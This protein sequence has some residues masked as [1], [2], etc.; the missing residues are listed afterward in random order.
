MTD[1]LLW[2]AV[3][4]GCRQG[5]YMGCHLRCLQ[6]THL[7]PAVLP[8][9]PGMALGPT[10]T[11]NCS[12][13]GPCGVAPGGLKC[14][15]YGKYLAFSK[16]YGTCTTRCAQCEHMPSSPVEQYSAAVL[17]RMQES[18]PGHQAM[19]HSM[20]ECWCHSGSCLVCC[21]HRRWPCAEAEAQVSMAVVQYTHSI[22]F[23]V[24]SDRLTCR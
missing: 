14:T 1:L 6:S 3:F 4:H 15:S 24:A 2:L 21:R 10:T 17:T 23:G 18:L 22:G 20:Q 13:P 11:V 12:S 8:V 5:W 19:P 16:V 9:A 7:V